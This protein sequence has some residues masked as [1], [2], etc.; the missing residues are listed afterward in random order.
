MRHPRAV[1]NAVF[2]GALCVT[3]GLAPAT[4]AKVKVGFVGQSILHSPGGIPQG[5]FGQMTTHVSG[6]N[7]FHYFIQWSGGTAADVPHV[8][9]SGAGLY[10]WVD[11]NGKLKSPDTIRMVGSGIEF[12]VIGEG[13]AYGFGMNKA[14][15]TPEFKGTTDA[16]AK[17]LADLARSK[18]V[19]PVVYVPYAHGP[20]QSGNWPFKDPE[21]VMQRFIEVAKAANTAYIPAAHA[22]ALAVA[23]YGDGAIYANSGSDPL[24]INDR[25]QFIAA[26][27]TW[28]VVSQTP[29]DQIT[30][31]GNPTPMSP[32]LI[33][34]GTEICREA[35][36]KYPQ[37]PTLLGKGGGMTSTGADAGSPGN[38]TDG[39]AGDEEPPPVVA[40]AG[41]AQAPEARPDAAPI[42][43]PSSTPKPSTPPAT[44]P[45]TPAA[46]G[47]PVGGGDD[48]AGPE[49][50][51]GDRASGGCA[52]GASSRTTSPAGGF[53][54]LTLA[55]LWFR[56]RT[57]S[58]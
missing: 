9:G 7:H 53:V 18:G 14:S 50:A 21:K 45:S 29:P 40:D 47:E 58:S 37:D 15:A 6:R 13:T 33:A 5:T 4:E 34:E 51:T 10:H 12:F 55:L 39:G 42:T 28:A 38:S 8:T 20:R 16:R 35:V 27:V 3:L 49:E 25:G 44:K 24:H 32:A 30:Y 11:E 48:P 31:K 23:K 19:V 26:C 36:K 52:V 43:T 41:V 22:I 1:R 17:V 56:R 46:S 2:G 57:R 54:A